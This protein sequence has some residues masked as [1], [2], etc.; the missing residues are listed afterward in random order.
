MPPLWRRVAAY[1]WRRR[2]VHPRSLISGSTTPDASATT[3]YVSRIDS[4][5]SIFVIDS[6]SIDRHDPKILLPFR[7]DDNFGTLLSF[8]C[9][10]KWIQRKTNITFSFNTDLVFFSSREFYYIQM[11]KYARQA[12]SEGLKVADDLH[13]AGDSEL[14]RVLNLHYNRNNHIE[15]SNRLHA[16]VLAYLVVSFGYDISLKA[17]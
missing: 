14:Y 13:V 15:V 1:R 5:V 10:N 8:I 16:S 12:I 9:L 4:S 11:E 3:D 7:T 6:L 17:V 2:H